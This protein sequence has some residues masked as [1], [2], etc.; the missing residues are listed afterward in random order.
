V[1]HPPATCAL[2]GCDRDLAGRRGNTR[3][4][5]QKHR[6][7]AFKLRRVVGEGAGDAL[8]TFPRPTPLSD[9]TP[10]AAKRSEVVAEASRK[11]LWHLQRLL[12]HGTGE[13]VDAFEVELLAI[14]RERRRRAEIHERAM[15]MRG[16]GN[17]DKET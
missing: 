7:D 9:G 15:T 6:G 8:E 14:F 1:T 5:C 16:R 12:S 10:R 4:C 17:V 2:P 3:Y 11:S 13:E